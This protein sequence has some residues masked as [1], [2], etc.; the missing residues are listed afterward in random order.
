MNAI[1]PFVAAKRDAL[2]RLCRDNHVHKL[3]LFGSATTGEFDPL[4]SDLDFLLELEPLPP[5]EYGAA[6]FALLSGLEDLYGVRIDL[7]TLP[8]IRNPML[9]ELIGPSRTVL[10][11]A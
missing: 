2:Q 10:Y 3:E 7:L 8:S 11:A 9:L 4:R 1:H 5:R 6:Y